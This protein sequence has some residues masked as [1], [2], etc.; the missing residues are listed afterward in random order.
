VEGI[1]APM[2]AAFGWV[3]ILCLTFSL[4]ESKWIL[5]AHLAHSKPTRNALLLKIDHLQEAVNTALRWFIHYRYRPFAQR[6]IRNRY[7]TLATFLSVL[8]LAAGL[9]AGGVV[10]TVLSPHTPGEFISVEITMTAGSPEEST[11]EAITHVIGTLEEIDRQ[12]QRETGSTASIYTHI[13]AHGYDRINGRIEVELSKQDTRSISNED[14]MRRWREATGRIHGTDILAFES[15]DG[16][17]FGPNIGFDLMHADFGMLR[18]AA[19]ELEEKLRHYEGLSDIRNGA[20]DT[21][22]EFHLDI[23]PE[24]ETLGLTRLALGNQ[25][26]HAFYGAE[27]QRIQRGIDEIKVMVRY[28]KADRESISS[29]KNM[30]IRTPDGDEVPFETVARLSV[31]QGLLKSTRI[32]FQR[33]AEITAEAD[34]AIV[35]PSKVIEDIEQTILPGLMK[36]YPGLSWAISGLADEESKMAVSMGIGFALSLFGIYALLAIP[37]R[38]YLQPLIIMGVIPFGVIGAVIGHWLTGHDVS[39]MS[40]MGIIAL[41][42]VVVNDSLILVDYV[43]KA[44][45]E[46]ADKRDAIVDAGCRRFRA[47]MLTSVTTFLGLAP[48]ILERSAQAQFMIPMAVA[49]AF[50][51]IFATVITLLLVPSLYIILD[52]LAKLTA[53]TGEPANDQPLGIEAR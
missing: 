42:G 15:S 44:V 3:V 11:L 53:K 19:E 31:E 9:V 2:T 40:V 51:I 39:M 34:I 33:A 38:S 6:C 25:V 14:I 52:D 24:A 36:K 49:L 43:N 46:G 12:Y 1:F 28:P 17:S 27:A 41:S 29:L 48:M 20:S 10:R 47:I 16:P 5:P 22:D 8:I 35:E 26:R 18:Q 30:F 7:L 37:T 21:A 23:L 50:G 45:L 32:D 13:G 4:I